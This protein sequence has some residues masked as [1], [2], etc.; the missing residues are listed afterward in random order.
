MRARIANEIKAEGEAMTR[1]DNGMQRCRQ[2]DRQAG[3]CEAIVAFDVRRFTNDEVERGDAVGWRL[4]C[5]WF[6]RAS[7]LRWAWF[8]REEQDDGRE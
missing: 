7:G 3:D 5:G 1:R 6:E 4:W 2:E 8:I